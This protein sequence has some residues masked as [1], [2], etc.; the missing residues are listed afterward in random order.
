[1]RTKIAVLMTT[2]FAGVANAHML[3]ADEGLFLRLYHQVLGMHHLP[4]LL[5]IAVAAWLVV[6]K[7]RRP[8]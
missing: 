5:L 8:D 6:R 7:A 2:G 4:I 1:M 3:G